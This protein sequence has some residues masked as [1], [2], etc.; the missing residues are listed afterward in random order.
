[1]NHHQVNIADQLHGG[2]IDPA[3]NSGRVKHVARNTDTS[4]SLLDI[5]FDR[6]TNGHDGM[7]EVTG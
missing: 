5:A 7:E 2:G 6:Q 4:E 1:M 3:D